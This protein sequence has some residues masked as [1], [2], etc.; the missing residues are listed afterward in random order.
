MFLNFRSIMAVP[1]VACIFQEGQAPHTAIIGC[2]DSRAPLE[3]VFDAMPGDIFVL[4]NAG[5]TCT[6]AEGSVMGSLELLGFPKR[7]WLPFFIFDMVF[8]GWVLVK[9]EK[10]NHL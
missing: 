4:R 9:D 6:H 7:S 5:N 10:N 3:L 1:F 2:A 8:W